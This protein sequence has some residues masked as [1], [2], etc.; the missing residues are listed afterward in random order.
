M[1]TIKKKR[2]EEIMKNLKSR[3]ISTLFNNIK[4]TK[5]FIEIL[6]IVTLKSYYE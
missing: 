1:T 4:I 3:I 5:S 6:Y 2:K